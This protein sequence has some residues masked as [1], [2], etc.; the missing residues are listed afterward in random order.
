MENRAAFEYGFQ[1]GQDLVNECFNEFCTSITNKTQLKFRVLEE[2]NRLNE[3]YEVV[4]T[5]FPLLYTQFN[6]EEKSDYYF[7]MDEGFDFEFEVCYNRQQN[8]N[9]ES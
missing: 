1:H 5:K 3:M 4:S 6:D 9:L 8:H 2:C 7:G